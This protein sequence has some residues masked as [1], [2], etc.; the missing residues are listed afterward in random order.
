MTRLLGDVGR[1]LVASDTHE[2]TEE[3]EVKLWS[4]PIRLGDDGRADSWLWHETCEGGLAKRPTEEK[5]D[6]KW[7]S[8]GQK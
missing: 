3:W 6:T 2:D 7:H 1:F 4:R 8:Q 5:E